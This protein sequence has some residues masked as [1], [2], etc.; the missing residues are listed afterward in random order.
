MTETQ[1]LA[2]P[3]GPNAPKKT[4]KAPKPVA[5]KENPDLPF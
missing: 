4:R 1:E 2:T 3:Q 5:E